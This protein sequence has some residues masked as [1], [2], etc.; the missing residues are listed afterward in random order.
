[1]WKKYTCNNGKE[2]LKY[3]FEVQE[4]LWLESSTTPLILERTHQ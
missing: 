1:M 2:T 3:T 4:E